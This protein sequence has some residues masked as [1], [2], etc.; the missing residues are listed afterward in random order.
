MEGGFMSFWKSYL[1]GRKKLIGCGILFAAIFLLSFLLY[2]LPLRAALYPM[3]ICACLGV[4]FL[5]VDGINQKR[6]MD[7][8]IRM[9]SSLELTLNDLAQTFDPVEEEYRQLLEAL[10]GQLQDQKATSAAQYRQ[11]MDYYTL[12]VHQIKTPIASMRLILEDEDSALSRKV[13]SQLLR[14]EQYVAMVLTYLRLDSEYSD[15]VIRDHVLADL[16]RPVIRK[17]A[18]EFIGRRIQLVYEPVQCHVV[19][20]EKWFCFVLEQ[21]LSNALKYTKEGRIEIVAERDE[22][23]IR[24]TGI[25]IAAQDLP[26]IFEKGYTGYNGRSDKRASGIGLYLCKRICDELRLPIRV[27]S[28]VGVGTSVYIG[29]C[30]EKVNFND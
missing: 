28:T 12:W 14:I 3:A 5:V 6:K 23:V 10:S 27:Q 22:L 25:G 29:L 11:M 17:F 2:H 30:Q 18:S 4:G 7:C 19:T 16:L 1:R 24:D 20:D 26:R 15:Y 21:L 9:C 8:L 13:R